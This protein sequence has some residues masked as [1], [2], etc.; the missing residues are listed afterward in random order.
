MVTVMIELP[1]D[2]TEREKE[3]YEELARIR[4]YNPRENIVFEK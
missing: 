1:P 4:K 2:L 3:L